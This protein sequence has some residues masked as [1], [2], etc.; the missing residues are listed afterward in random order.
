MGRVM[1]QHGMILAAQKVRLRRGDR[2]IL[3]AR[4]RAPTT[5][6]RH[7]LRARIVLAATAGRTTREIGRNLNTT[8]TA[9]SLWRIRYAQEGHDGLEDRDRGGSCVTSVARPNGCAQLYER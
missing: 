3:E 4:V 5:E 6:Q 8:P 7:V 1:I 2:A 9:V